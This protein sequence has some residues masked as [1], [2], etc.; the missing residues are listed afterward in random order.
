MLRLCA[1][2]GR[3]GYVTNR[4]PHLPSSCAL[5]LALGHLMIEL[6]R[7]EPDRANGRTVELD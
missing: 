3:R 1:R 6:G 5:A 2:W 7:R 4:R